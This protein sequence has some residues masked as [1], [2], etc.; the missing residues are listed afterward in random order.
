MTEEQIPKLVK[1]LLRGHFHQAAFFF[2]MGACAMLISQSHNAREAVA[3][4]VYSLGLVTLFGISALYHRPTW[5]P[6]PRAWMRRLDHAAIFVMIAGTGTPLSLLAISE[7]SGNKLLMIFWGAAIIGIIQS[8]VWV[9]APKLLS[10]ILYVLM[11]WLAVPYLPEIQAALGTGSIVLLLAGGVI[12]TLGAL[13]YAFKTPNPWPAVFGYH[14]IFHLMV[15][16]A[17]VLHFLV[18]AGLMR[19]C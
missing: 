19:S 16:I 1:P 7:E 13:V 3:M 5:S 14:E 6:G 11:G 10:A 17:A 2:A 8:V 15:I 9:N 4:V 12:Y 18:I